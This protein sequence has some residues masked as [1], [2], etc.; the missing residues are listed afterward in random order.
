MS[1]DRLGFF[2]DEH[3]PYHDERAV[4]LSLQILEDFDPDKLVIGSD[5]M[6]FHT[7][8][9]FST[10]PRLMG[11]L[12]KERLSF[13]QGVE[14]KRS[15]CP[16]AEIIYIR[17]NHED[18][19][20]RYI[21]QV[22]EVFEGEEYTLSGWLKLDDLGI[23][24]S[25]VHFTLGPDELFPEM[26]DVPTVSKRVVINENLTVM[27][28]DYIR[29]WQGRSAHAQLYEGERMQTSLLMGHCHRGGKWESSDRDGEPIGAYECYHHQRTD[30]PWLSEQNPDWS[31]GIVL[32]E[33]QVTYP[34]N[35]S[36]EQVNY[37]PV[38]N[39]LRARWRGNEYWSS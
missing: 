25:V 1:W 12:R 15:A 23:R 6:D 39:R 38:G 21:A 19:F 34:Y 4:S 35:F 28:G 20:P 29:K 8:S 27:H 37:I 3:R 24:Y 13:W 31:W 22:S 7:I 16:N 33:Y 5:G 30:M 17:G 32:A 2:T 14:E 26:I 11:T 36:I 18:R 10:D 9:H